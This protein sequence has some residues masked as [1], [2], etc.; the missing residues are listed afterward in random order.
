M[1][2]Q[3]QCIRICTYICRYMVPNTFSSVEMWPR[4]AA[5]KID[6]VMLGKQADELECVIDADTDELAAEALVQSGVDSLGF[7]RI[8]HK[9]EEDEEMYACSRLTDP[10]V[11]QW[12]DGS[13][14]AA[15]D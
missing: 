11:S 5:A 10:N 3:Y 13:D 4:S 9:N 2:I 6:R 7:M 15:M 8:R 14:R 12:I 1:C